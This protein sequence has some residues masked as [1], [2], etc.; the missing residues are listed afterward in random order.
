[1]VTLLTRASI[2]LEE[3]DSDMSMVDYLFQYKVIF[4]DLI[5]EFSDLINIRMTAENFD[6][7]MMI[8]IS[9]GI[10]APYTSEV[11]IDTLKKI[12]K[13]RYQESMR[14]HN[15][16][17][18][19]LNK[20]LGCY[21]FFIYAMSST[22]TEMISS[23]RQCGMSGLKMVKVEG[24]WCIPELLLD[25]FSETDGAHMASCL[26][27]CKF[28][29]SSR[30]SDLSAA[31]VLVMFNE[32]RKLY[33]EL[34]WSFY[35]VLTEPMNKMLA[36]ASTPLLLNVVLELVTESSMSQA[37]KQRELLQSSML[38]KLKD[39]K[40]DGVLNIDFSDSADSIGFIAPREEMT[41]T[42]LVKV[43]V[44]KNMLRRI[45]DNY[46]EDDL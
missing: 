25:F 34:A 6:I 19:P 28:F 12:L 20:Q 5:A 22:D 16:T 44:L 1:M 40:L 14:M 45:R 17:G 29:G 26:V 2:H 41:A 11:C 31:R 21:I 37:F 46:E 9:K 36:T 18:E 42:S 43:G 13:L 24:K 38:E 3:T 27:I 8:L 39:S 30:I 10:Q 7:I 15:K 33:P 4:D 32:I 35:S 23:L